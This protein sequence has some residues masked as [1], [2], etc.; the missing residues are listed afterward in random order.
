MQA[1]YETALKEIAGAIS[2]AIVK[3]GYSYEDV[4]STAGVSRAFGD[5]SSSIA[6][7]L[8]KAYRKGPMEIASQVKGAMALP[9]CVES[10]TTE[11]AY[12]NFHLRRQ[13]FTRGAVVDA[14]APEDVVSAVGKGVKVTVESPSVN[15]NKPWHVGH[16][17]NA[18]LGDV[19]SNL[20]RACSY[21]VERENYIDD[22]GIQVAESLWGYMRLNS[23]PEGKFDYWLGEQ[24]VIVNK[25]IESDA[26]VKTEIAEVSALMEQD[27]T[28]EA[29]MV[30]ELA[31]KCLA[32]Q[33]ETAFNYGI[34]HD[35]LVW[36]SDIVREKLMSKALETLERLKVVEKPADGKYKGCIVI[37]MTTIKDL[38]QAIAGLREDMRVLVRSDGTPTYLGKDIAHH[39]WKLGILAD[40]FKYS[41]FMVRKPDGSPIITT[42]QE[43]KQMS[44]GNSKI[45]INV[46][47]SEQELP[48]MILA[49]AFRLIGAGR[50]GGVILHMSYGKVEVEGGL[51]GRK[52]TWLA[53][54]TADNMLKEAVAKAVSAMGP[55][56]KLSE[57]ET[58]RIAKSVAVASIKFEYLRFSP[59][60]Q[61]QFSWDRA[62]NFEGASGPYC[63]YMHARAMRMLEDGHFSDVTAN[64]AD[65]QGMGDS[66]FA[67]I[68][69]IA[70]AGSVI[71]KACRELRP[72]VLAEYASDL[73]YAFG[74]FYESVP[75][76]RA[77]DEKQRTSRLAVTSA[78]ARTMSRIL[79]IM[80]IEAPSRM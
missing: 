26:S 18:I 62:L 39:M 46:I 49:L 22:L 43:G 56:F 58:K 55:R 10:V 73:A 51:S 63:Q 69:Q 64:S 21:D 75:V 4:A 20:F 3:L 17:R 25:E 8:A 70:M 27:G 61:I 1:Q 2:D 33:Y 68:K 24:Y 32:A 53:G 23:K 77:T 36:E 65:F 7:G 66:E 67:L 44:F 71:E 48:Q 19:I 76:L 34:T 72:N 50:P 37:N 35:V 57:E 79:G 41:E 31:T 13:P 29:T 52:G 74:K 47:G 28:Y 6:F 14:L 78:F 9:S 80:G 60:R 5:I 40:T 11:N 45:A 38:P 15:P 42:S 16:L 30:R 59:E 12:L 54:Y